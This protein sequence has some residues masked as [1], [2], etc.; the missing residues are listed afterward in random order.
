M[1][2][3]KNTLFAAA[4]VVVAL[5]AGFGLA[6][7]TDRPAAAQGEAEA[8]EEHAEDRSHEQPPLV[9]PPLVE[10]AEAGDAPG[11]EGGER[12]VAEVDDRIVIGR[13]RH[14]PTGG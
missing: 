12:A 13:D 3:E 6:R 8:G 11:K 14:R 10:V 2:I 1:P 4:A 7:F 5:G 9:L